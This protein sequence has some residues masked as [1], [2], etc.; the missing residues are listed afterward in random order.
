MNKLL[1]INNFKKMFN[2]L[3]IIIKKVLKMVKEKQHLNSLSII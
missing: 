2:I 3:I 1:N